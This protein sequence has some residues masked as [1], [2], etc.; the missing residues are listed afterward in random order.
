MAEPRKVFRIQQTAAAR[1]EEAVEATPAALLHT[2]V[3]REL[4]A[5]RKALAAM[6]PLHARAIAAPKH[7]VAE[8][9]LVAG[10]MNGN[11]GDRRER[12]ERDRGD[13]EAPIVRIDR[14][15]NAVVKGTEQAAQ[16]ILAVAEEIDAAATSL[17]AALDGKIDQGLAQDI[18][19]LVIQIFEAC[20]FQDLIG[21]RVAKVLAALKLVEDHVAGVLEE[22]TLPS[23]ALHGPRLD[24][25]PGHA[26]QDD[27]DTIF[28]SRRPRST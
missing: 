15:L 16:K 13:T 12:N 7:G 24:G 19:D 1:P 27:I 9:D 4:A 25:D 17:S 5:L 23:P 22:V 18:Q 14:E 3:M 6:A 26:S 2:E 20:N 28:A 10:A 8:L 11:A 21:Q